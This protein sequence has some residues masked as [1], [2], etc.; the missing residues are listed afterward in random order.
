[1]DKIPEFLDSLRNSARDH[2]SRKA[3]NVVNAK[4]NVQEVVTYAE[5]W[6]KTGI[7]ATHFLKEGLKKGDRVMIIYPNTAQ[8]E[9]LLAFLACLRV[10][11]VPVSIY[12]PNPQKIDQDLVKF[13]HYVNNAGATTAITTA[14]YKRFVQLSSVT[15]TWAIPSK[16][17]WATDKLVQKKIKIDEVATFYNPTD[18]DLMFIQYTSGSTGLKT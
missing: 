6:E 2:G 3:I 12:P 9:Y 1:M 16:N 18:D 15:K 5:V 7:L 13:Q 8:T 14:E 10:G 17:W 11:I 4:C